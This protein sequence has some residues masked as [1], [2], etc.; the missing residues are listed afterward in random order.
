[1]FN[2]VRTQ[3][4]LDY[5]AVDK[6]QERGDE[7]QYGMPSK[8]AI[9]RLFDNKNKSKSREPLVSELL[10]WNSLNFRQRSVIRP[11]QLRRLGVCLKIQKCIFGERRSGET[12]G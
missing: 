5:G 1:M 3:N 4:R 2:D 10:G 12:T 9:G 7:N 11:I 8:L 6:Q